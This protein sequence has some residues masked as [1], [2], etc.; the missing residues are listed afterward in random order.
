MLSILLFQ[1]GFLGFVYF[2]IIFPIIVMSLTFHEV[3]HA[4]AAYFYGD[5]TAKDQG[6]ITLN[7]MKHLDLVGTLL[8]VFVGFGYAK[9][10]PISPMK[11]RKLRE[12]YFVTAIA[13]IVVNLILAILLFAAS[14]FIPKILHPVIHIGI[15]I[16]INLAIFNLFPIYPMDGGRILECIWNKGRYVS[17]WLTKNNLVAIGLMLF[18]GFY[19]MPKISGFIMRFIGLI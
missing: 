10:V 9:P 16:N 5:S 3:G 17:Q 7:P 2:L 13:G 15:A 1:N 8:L 12:G 19:I 18:A 11:F 4:L 14:Y 6:R